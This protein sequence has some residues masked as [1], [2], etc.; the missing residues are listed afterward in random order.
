MSYRVELS[1]QAKKAFSALRERD[2]RLIGRRLLGLAEN[3]RPR[4]AKALT[5]GLKGH[6]RVRV[7]DQR[8]VYTVQDKQ[9]L[10]R[11]VRIGPRHSIY[12]DAERGT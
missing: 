6:Y 7:G 3:P 2:R 10:V 4:G 9:L 1:R 11:V 5:R 12:D 8:I